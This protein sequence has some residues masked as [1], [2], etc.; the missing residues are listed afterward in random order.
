MRDSS[1]NT[2]SINSDLNNT[3]LYKS[4]VSLNN[5]LLKLEYY[6]FF[7]R[8]YILYNLINTDLDITG[9]QIPQNRAI[10]G[11]PVYVAVLSQML[12]HK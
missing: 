9:F 1:Y 10:R 6:G 12:P 8:N 11:V 3:A 5:T 4:P 2:D 7:K